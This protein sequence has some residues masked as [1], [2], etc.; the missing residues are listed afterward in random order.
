MTFLNWAMLAGLAAV[1]IPILIHLLNRQKATLVDWGAMRFL[2]ESLTS[3]SRRILIEEIILMVL[4]CLVI[5]LLVLAMA[6]PF[7]PSRTT[8]PWALVLPAMIAAL[9]MV[10]IAAAVW[11]HA[12]ARWTLLGVAGGLAAIAIGAS[13]AENVSQGRQWL[14][15]GERDVAILIDG[16]TSMTVPVDG[17]TNFK[18]AVD[19]AAT[20]IKAC[21]PADAISI[22]LAGPVPRP[23]VANPT[24][25]RDDLD[26]ALRTIVPT[27][28]SMRVLDSLSAAAASL[29]EGH[30]PAKKIV[31][32]T[33]D[34]NIGWDPRNEAR[35]KFLAAGLRSLPV[36]P[37]IVCRT[38]ALP[39]AFRNAA[40]TDVR[41]SRKVV[42]TD[43]PV[44][45]DVTV[46]NTGTTPLESLAVELAIDG[47][48]VARQDVA[49]TLPGAAETVRFDYRFEK[50]GPH[51]IAA[52]VLSEDEMPSDNTAVR[53]LTVIDKLPVLIVEGDPSTRPLDGAASF[54]EI[55]LTPKEDEDEAKAAA[56]KTPAK[57]GEKAPPPAEPELGSLVE[58]TVVP[59]TDVGSVSDL[60]QFRLVILANVPKL[61]AAA[62]SALVRYVQDGGG[63]LVALGD[64][65]L[66]TF[67]NSWTTDAGQPFIPAV[68]LRRR[69]LGESPAHF[70]LKTFSHPALE[71]LRDSTQNDGD[72]AVIASFWGLD[73]DRKDRAVRAGGLFDTGEPMLVER[74]VGKGYVLMTAM[75]LDRR[76]SNLPSLK[77]FVPLVHELAY[78]LTTPAL[79]QTNVR[80]GS[81]FVMELPARSSEAARRAADYA[82][83]TAEVVTPTQRRLSAAMAASA[84]GLRVNFAGTYEPGLYRLA[85]PAKVAEEFAA[86]G[87]AR[88]FPFSVVDDAEE[89]RLSALTPA[90]LEA[91]GKQ[92]DFFQARSTNEAVSAVTD[93][94]PG[95]ELWK[96]LAVALLV[97]L[98]AEIG[99]TR[100]IAGQRRMHMIETV[101]FG[102]ETVD[103]QT[104]RDRARR[105]LGVP[106]QEPQG[107]PKS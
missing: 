70:G 13:I 49:Q 50:P 89:G 46:T 20:I 57:A 11:A 45:I 101:A 55:A 60:R 53:V 88:H 42:G 76:E 100:W 15:G 95:E 59:V 65:V 12:R 28:G 71:L 3:R 98:L 18:R 99:L 19:E 62:A 94:V 87:T 4:R 10:G 14:K 29:A 16:S 25:D 63:L 1:A 21:R 86:P 106:A 68:L 92:V 7:L 75:S 61:P 32:I 8:I 47:A 56:P 96:Y 93:T 41:F 9:I 27:G 37:Q 31:L 105:L 48:A 81:E 104:F 52:R 44:R 6:R 51:T 24:A 78:Y 2:L 35:W 103:V 77:C 43:R 30:N 5:G 17:Q 91:V 22:I 26:N 72:R 83:L 85:L 82:R 74:Q 40:A 64:K 67:Y 23:V 79:A 39:K 69:A 90:D 107:A 54:V 102:P 58:P 34:Q 84:G 80:P 38:L 66:P 33:D 73:V 97:G 36:P